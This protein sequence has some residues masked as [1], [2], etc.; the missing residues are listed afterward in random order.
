[1]RHE[2]FEQRLKALIAGEIEIKGDL[3]EYVGHAEVL[4][5]LLE[6][7]PD[8]VRDDLQF[9]YDLMV[10]T[11]DATGAAVLGIFP[12]LCNPEL[13]NVEGRISDYAA[14]HCGIR[15]GDG[16]YEAGFHATGTIGTFG[17]AAAAARMLGLDEEA[18]ARAFGIAASEAAGLKS[19]F[20]TMTKPL[21]AGKA[22]LNGLMA[23]RLAARGFTARTDAIET[24]G[25]LLPTHSISI[26]GVLKEDRRIIGTFVGTR[27][28][29]ASFIPFRRGDCA[30]LSEATVLLA[31][32]VVKWLKKPSLDARLG[33]AR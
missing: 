13:A 23:A 22:A 9:L 26:D 3:N 12:R 17:A 2:I 31:K 20:G 1:M 29:R 16:H 18:T 24:S 6:V 30:I 14:E 21:H 5:L 27:F 4:G 8:E 7:A 25:G 32:D 28:A 15:Y 10:E 19:N 11:R 33:D